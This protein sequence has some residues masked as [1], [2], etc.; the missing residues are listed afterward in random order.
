MHNPSQ[1]SH[2]TIL[3]RSSPS[4]PPTQSKIT[5]KQHKTPRVSSYI[6]FFLVNSAPNVP[7]CVM[8]NI[9]IKKAP[10]NTKIE[11]KRKV[12]THTKK[13]KQLQEQGQKYLA[14]NLS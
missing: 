2:A 1:L 13:A 8:L 11:T 7:Y 14:L 12:N 4:P 10:T 9:F 6:L 3:Q 5:L